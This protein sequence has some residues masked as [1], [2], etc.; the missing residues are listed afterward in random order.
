LDLRDLRPFPTRRSSDLSY[1]RLWPGPIMSGPDTT[2]EFPL[3]IKSAFCALS[4]RYPEGRVNELCQPSTSLFEV[5]VM[6]TEASNWN[7]DACTGV[8]TAAHEI[9]GSGSRV[10]DAVGSGSDVG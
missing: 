7:H 4:A 5:F 2:P 9:P 6:V 1:V 8:A 10:G 3:S